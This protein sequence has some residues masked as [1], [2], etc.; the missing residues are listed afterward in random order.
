M[1][2]R[3]LLEGTLSRHQ[4]NFSA[5]AKDLGMHRTTLRKR[6]EELNLGDG[7]NH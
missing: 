7:S 2:E 5:A 3:P 6:M 1:F 4:G